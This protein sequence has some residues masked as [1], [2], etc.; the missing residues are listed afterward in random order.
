MLLSEPLAGQA[1]DI[2]YAGLRP[3]PQ[4]RKFV[5][6]HIEGGNFSVAGDDEIGSG[7]LQA[8]TSPPLSS[9]TSSLPNC[10]SVSLNSVEWM[11]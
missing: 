6:K 7:V 10:A 1:Q 4:L 9:P 11:R 8:G 5:E 3:R 2:A